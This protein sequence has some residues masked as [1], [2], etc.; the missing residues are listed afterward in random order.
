MTTSYFPRSRTDAG[1]F[2]SGPSAAGVF[3]T[4]H[5][6]G[7]GGLTAARAVL[8]QVSNHTDL[9]IARACRIVL[10]TH[11]SEPQERT[12]AQALFARLPMVVSAQVC[13]SMDG[14]SYA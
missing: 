9:Q 12:D 11:R 6:K 1:T 2:P 5:G 7:D 14:R 3:S 10:D 8:A 4:T 13:G